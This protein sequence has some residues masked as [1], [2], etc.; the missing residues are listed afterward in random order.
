MSCF[1]EQIAL[2]VAAVRSYSQADNLSRVIWRAHAQGLLSDDAAQAAAE[3]LQ[4]R[5]RFL[6]SR[7]PAAPKKLF[8]GP[9]RRFEPRSPDRERSLRRRRACAMSGAVPAKLAA[10]FTLAEI[11]ALSIIAAEN[12]RKDICGL[13]IDAIAAMAGT[14]R[15]VVKRALRLAAALGLVSVEHRPQPG[16]KSLPNLVRII[17]RDW[18]AWLRLGDRGPKPKPYR[19][20]FSKSCRSAP[21]PQVGAKSTVQHAAAPCQPTKMRSGACPSGK[22]PSS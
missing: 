21:A 22:Q 4:A 6:G 18:R 2:A 7:T 13:P 15:S 20:Q 9:P 14:S 19:Y 16:R 12:R 11:A 17:S 1:S 3:M 5:K 8:S 10:S